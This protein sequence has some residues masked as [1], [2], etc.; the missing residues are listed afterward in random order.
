[1]I[2]TAMSI[3]EEAEYVFIVCMMLHKVIRECIQ[4]A[5]LFTKALPKERFEY[6]VHR[7]VPTA[8]KADE[9]MLQ[10][11]IQVSLA[12]QKSHE[13]QEA[14]ENVALVYEHLATEEIEKLVEESKNVDDSSPSRHDDTSIPGTRLDV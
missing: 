2:C 1:M 14:R 10:D 6:L 8:K 13:E 7:I 4:L 5:D 12:E 11:I 3:A 9:M